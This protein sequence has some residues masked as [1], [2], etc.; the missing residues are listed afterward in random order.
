MRIDCALQE[1]VCDS[2][3]LLERL[4]MDLHDVL[5]DAEWQSK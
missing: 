3:E 1:D 5:Q 2:E 4:L